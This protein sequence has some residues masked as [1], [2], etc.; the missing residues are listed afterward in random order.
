MKNYIY[1][2]DSYEWTGNEPW[3]DAWKSAVAKAKEVHTG[4][5][6]RVINLEREEDECVEFYAKGG[7]FLNARFYADH[8]LK[9]F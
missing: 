8:K 7:C 5:W 4:I 3:G 6:R 9:I 2:V 1:T